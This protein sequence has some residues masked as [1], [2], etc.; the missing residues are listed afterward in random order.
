MRGTF[1]LANEQGAAGRFGVA[2]M[3]VDRVVGED[4]LVGGFVE[5]DT[6]IRDW[7]DASALLRGGWMAG[8]YATMRVLDNVYVDLMGSGG[9]SAGITQARGIEGRFAADTG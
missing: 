2:A 3:G 8:G 9:S 4:L 5:A 1:A 7:S 6:M